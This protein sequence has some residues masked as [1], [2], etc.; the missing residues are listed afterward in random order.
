MILGDVVDDKKDPTNA[1][2][3]AFKELY[4]NKFAYMYMLIFEKEFL[5]DVKQLNIFLTLLC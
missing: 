2:T 3:L 1:V 4:V 5:R